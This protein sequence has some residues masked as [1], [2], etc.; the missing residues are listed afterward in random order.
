MC[1]YMYSFALDVPLTD[2]KKCWCKYINKP[3]NRENRKG[4]QEWTIQRLFEH[5]VPDEF[6]EQINDKIYT[7]TNVRQNTN[8]YKKEPQR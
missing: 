4:T 7:N 1:Y 6:S 5:Y 3:I 8:S 2:N